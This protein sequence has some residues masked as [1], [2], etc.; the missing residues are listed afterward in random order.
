MESKTSCYTCYCEKDFNGSKP[1]ENNPHCKKDD[2]GILLRSANR[3]YEG[4]APLYYKDLKCCPIDWICENEL[5][6][7]NKQKATLNPH[8]PCSL[9]N[10]KFNIGDK[11]NLTDCKTCACE[12]PPMMTCYQKC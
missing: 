5:E 9:G 7:I 3:L 4:C 6:T 10:L 11:F 12:V 2:C 1:F 8:N